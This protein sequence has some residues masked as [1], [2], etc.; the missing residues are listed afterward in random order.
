MLKSS[1]FKPPI[2]QIGSF[3]ADISLTAEVASLFAETAA[4]GEEVNF[5]H[6]FWLIGF[7]EFIW[8]SSFSSTLCV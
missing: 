2:F 4:T 1:F 5:T 6:S 7:I 3:W 8:I